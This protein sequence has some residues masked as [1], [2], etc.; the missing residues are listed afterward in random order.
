MDLRFQVAGLGSRFVA[1]LIDHAIQFGFYL[2]LILVLV[3]VFSGSHT[4]SAAATEELDTAGKWFVAAF[5]FANFCIIWGYFSLFEA[6]WKGQTPGKRVMRLRVIKDSGRQITF[7]EALARNLLRAIDYLPSLY[8]VGVITMLCNKSNKRLGDYAAGTIVVHE[9]RDAQPMFVQAPTFLMPNIV[10]FDSAVTNGSAMFPSDAIAK[11]NSK[12]LLVIDTFFGRALD[13][14][15]ETRAAM[16]LRVATGMCAKMGTPLP[17]GS[18][19]RA[20]EA[21]A[22][23][24]RGLGRSL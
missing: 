9:V 17:E 16:A 11:L 22:V 24:M 19:E 21:M 10:P 23:Q 1:I 5:I 18:P 2:L 15:M 20:L 14:S 13:L 7:F 3:L 6:F 12:D 8:L 4:T